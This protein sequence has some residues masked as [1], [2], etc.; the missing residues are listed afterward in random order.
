[1]NEPMKPRY[2]PAEEICNS[3][4]H[5][6]GAILA[7]CSTC[8]LVLNSPSTSFAVAAVV[9]GLA[10]FSMFLTSAL[11]HAVRDPGAK[12]V[13]RKFDHAMIYFAI[14]GTYV[15]ILNAVTSPRESL[16]WY[17][18][19]GLCVLVGAASSFITLKHKYVTTAVY[20]VMGWASLLLLRNL[21]RSAEPVTTY[22]LIGGGVAYSIGAALY[23][24][25][26]RFMHAVFHVFVLGGAALQYLSIRTFYC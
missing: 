20:L 1:M 14:A 11:Y 12:A 13:I 15:P 25:K 10:V 22:L 19:L 21:W 5:A 23:L 9:Y 3:A 26:K 7:V 6:L 18:G 2:T 4:S 17:C 16:V 8:L 24:L